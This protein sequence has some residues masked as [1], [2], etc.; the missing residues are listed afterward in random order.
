MPSNQK[1]SDVNVV[2]CGFFPPAGGYQGGVAT[3]VNDYFEN[4]NIFLLNGVIWL[5]VLHIF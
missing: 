5:M 4:Q 3:F 1:V 2:E